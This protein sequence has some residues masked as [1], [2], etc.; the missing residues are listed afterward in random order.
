MTHFIP[1]CALAEH[2]VLEGFSSGVSSLD[3]WL[4]NKARKNEYNRA[5]RTYV[6]CN[7]ERVIGYYALATGAILAHHAPSK[8]KRNMP[9]PI[10]VMV[11]GRLA[12]DQH[13]QGKGLGDALLRDAILRVLQAADIAG[14][15]AIL[16]HAL[17]ERAKQFYEDRSFIPS[18]VDPMTLVLPLN[19]ITP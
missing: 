13:Y 12:I 9:N 4:V 16:V 18:P 7:H 10:P 15:K 5:S 1:P 2:H 17:S 8:V 11:L 19:S 14:I 3:D 6:L